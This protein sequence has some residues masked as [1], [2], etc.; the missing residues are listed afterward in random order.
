MRIL[1]SQPKLE[2]NLEQL[3]AELMMYP[4]ITAAVFPEGYLHTNLPRACELAARTRTLL[5]S[6]SK[7]PKDRAVIINRG[8]EVVM[9]RAK[10]SGYESVLEE[11]LL[12]TPILCD[13]LVL[14]EVGDANSPRTDLFVQPIGVGMFSEEQFDEWVAKAKEIA[15]RHHAMVIGTSHA[16]GSFRGS[17][18]SLPIAYWIDRDGEPL[19]ISNGDVRSRIVDLRNKEITV[20]EPAAKESVL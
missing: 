11:G 5:I 14:R 8:G 1:V 18:V 4:D 17:E 10:Y 16:D 20:C 9:D 19:F 15:S 3:Q 6:G 13:E 7:N 12:I 2:R